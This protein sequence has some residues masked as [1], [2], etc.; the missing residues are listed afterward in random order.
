MC[1]H[2]ILPIYGT[3][4]RRRIIAGTM[5]R[6]IYKIPVHYE[7]GARGTRNRDLS[8]LL[9]LWL[10]RPDEAG[11]MFFGRGK[12]RTLLNTVWRLLLE[13]VFESSL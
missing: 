9:C 13:S 7:K 11:N 3:L 1:A 2:S 6:E 4:L 5:E 8:L 12:V 10:G